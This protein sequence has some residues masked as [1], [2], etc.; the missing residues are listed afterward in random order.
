ML[1]FTWKVKESF[2]NVRKDVENFKENVSQWIV[3]LGDRN[4]EMEKRLD[5]IENKIDRLEEA[6]FKVLS[7]R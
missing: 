1:D 2:K 3:F 5:K 6:M 7:L 4:S